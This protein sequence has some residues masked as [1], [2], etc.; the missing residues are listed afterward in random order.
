MATKK[1]TILVQSIL[2]WIQASRLLSLPMIFIPLGYG[3]YVGNNSTIHSLWMLIPWGICLNLFIIFTNDLF[4]LE[5]DRT[6]QKK[7]FYSSGSRALVEKKISYKSLKTASIIVF[8]MYIALSLELSIKSKNF[9]IALISSCVCI[10]TVILNHFPPFRLSYRCFGEL[11]QAIGLGFILPITGQVF[12][13][14]DVTQKIPFLIYFTLT[15]SYFMAAIYMNIPD[16]KNDLM[17]KKHNIL[18]TYLKSSKQKTLF[19]FNI[20]SVLLW[21]I[22]LQNSLLLLGFNL[23]FFVFFY[24]SSNY[25]YLSTATGPLTF[26]GA[27]LF[28]GLFMSRNFIDF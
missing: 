4:D 9:T 16:E 28:L 12:S 5:V 18:N 15:F 13:A 22:F 10:S 21:Y 23:T 17:H 3:V 7:S 27:N 14:A 24:L 2:S 25:F 8:L 26:I 19:V 11:L 6:T 1:K 20:F